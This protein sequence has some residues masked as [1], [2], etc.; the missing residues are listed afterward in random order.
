MSSNKQTQW[1]KDYFELYA[2]ALA[3]RSV[4]GD[5]VRIKEA[6]TAACAGDNKAIIA[7]NGGSAAIASHLAVDFSKAAGMRTVS[8]NDP[9]LITCLANDYG[10][11]AWVMRAVEMHGRPGDVI[12]LISSS[13]QSK[14]M[15]LAAEK[16][17]AMGLFVVTLSG[18]DAD[19][20]LRQCGDVNLWV[21]SRAYNVVEG[22]HQIWLAA[23]CD[24]IVG[25]A[26]Y[27]AV[28]A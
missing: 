10:Y 11:E 8:F 27:P 16:A 4:D 22:L 2:E 3:D 1:L 25:K 9:S 6:L 12:F 24:L 14:N 28:Q 18:F 20:P 13:G 7:G 17:S 15:V 5:L 19:N 23:V 26:E 21:D